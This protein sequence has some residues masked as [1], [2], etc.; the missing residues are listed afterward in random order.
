MPTPRHAAV[1][2]GAG[3]EK[4]LVEL[5]GEEILHSFSLID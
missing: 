4:T 1:V 2:V 5:R 3:E